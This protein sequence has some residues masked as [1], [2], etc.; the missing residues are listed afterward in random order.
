IVHRDLNPGNILLTPADEPMIMDFGLARR[1][2]SARM[3][4]PGQVLGTPG[5]IAPE[6]LSGNPEAQGPACDIF[7]LGGI[8]Y[9]LLTG[10]LPFGR[11]LNEVLLRIMTT[12]PRLP[13]ACRQGV[14]PALDAICLKA[15]ARK[16]EDRYPSMG[17]LAEALN[18]YLSN[19]SL[20]AQP[21]IV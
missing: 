13:S 12:D 11:S 9:E 6:Q 17:K 4:L 3:T 16:V 21:T 2:G 14:D 20:F 18:G 7:S 8:L 1:E 5:Y 10:E 19:R 15:L